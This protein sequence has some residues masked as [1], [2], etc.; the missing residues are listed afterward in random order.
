M[1]NANQNTP[2]RLP[3]A[4]KAKPLS[5]ATPAERERS[6]G[7]GDVE[8]KQKPIFILVLCLPCFCLIE[9]FHS[10]S[11]VSLV[12]FFPLMERNEHMKP[13]YK[14]KFETV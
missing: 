14:S 4:P 2:K 12:R 6:W 10:L 8:I 7:G 1:Y 9:T 5:R 11:G 13:T 3:L